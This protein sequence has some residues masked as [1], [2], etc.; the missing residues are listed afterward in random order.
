MPKKVGFT[1]VE[2]LIVIV[3]IG[4]LATLTI[5]AYSGVQDNARRASLQSDLSQAAKKLEEYKFKNAETFPANLTAAQSA[6][7]KQSGSNTLSYTA[8]TTPKGA[9]TGYCLQNTIN[10]LVYYVTGGGSVK[11]GA[12]RTVTNLIQNPNNETD[13][14]G[15]ISSNPS[16]ASIAQGQF[17]DT[18]ALIVNRLTANAVAIRAANMTFATTVGQTYTASAYVHSTVA[19]P[20]RIDFREPSTCTTTWANSSV[21]GQA[22]TLTRISTVWTATS[23][24]VCVAVYLSAGS[25]SGSVVSIDNAM[26]TQTSDLTEYADGSS[27][28]WNWTGTANASTS[29][30]PA[31]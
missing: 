11:E 18:N 10:S 17:N 5:I 6:G 7:V 13:I 22:N 20:L 29:S 23:T 8:Y 30:G 26:V 3:V 19:Q 31:L 2:L 16:D 25:Y 15:W 12:C 9:N 28:N 27:P 4:I 14:N 1:V 21:S 24:S